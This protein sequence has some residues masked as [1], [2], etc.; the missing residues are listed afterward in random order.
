[1]YDGDPD[2]QIIDAPWSWELREFVYRSDRT[3]WRASY[4]DMTLER[5]GCVR[6]LRFSAPRDLEMSRGLPNCDGM[7]ILDVSG[8]QM[9][10]ISV[11]VANFEESY[12]APTFW[13]A[14][15]VDTDV[16]PAADS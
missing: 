16:E 8:R 10:G 6:R 14:S 5:G 15:V 1:M 2:H 3:D 13:A 4:I 11:R 9:E 12:G 7:C